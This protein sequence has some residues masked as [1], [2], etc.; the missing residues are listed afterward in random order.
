M[1]FARG[2]ILFG[3]YAGIV[4][5]CWYLNGKTSDLKDYSGDKQWEDIW[6]V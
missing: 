5:M 3:I 2:S 4:L 6:P 1:T